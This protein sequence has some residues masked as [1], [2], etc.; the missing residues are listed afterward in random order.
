MTISLQ[1]VDITISFTSSTLETFCAS[2]QLQ[3]SFECPR[4]QLMSSLQNSLRLASADIMK[5]FRGIAQGGQEE[6]TTIRPD[7]NMAQNV[8]LLSDLNL[9]APLWML[10]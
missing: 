2:T 5:V 4:D 6:C 7:Q 8:E 9:S 3:M 10:K 1:N